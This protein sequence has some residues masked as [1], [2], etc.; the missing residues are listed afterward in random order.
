MLH[1]FATFAVYSKWIVFKILLGYLTLFMKFLVL[2][3]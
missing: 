2:L 3:R 1:S